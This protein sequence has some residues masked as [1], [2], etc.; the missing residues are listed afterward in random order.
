MA[1]QPMY[2]QIADVIRR[3]IESGELPRGGRLPTEIELC[4]RYNAS[5]N[6]IR[7]AIKRLISLRLVETRPGQGTFV[8]Q[9]TDPFVTTLSTDPA[10]GGGGGEGTSR[11]SALAS[12]DP[13]QH[14][15]KPWPSTPE[16]RVE[17]PQPW[18][19]RR[20]RLLSDS[21]QVIVREQR[22]HID[23]VPWSLQTTYYPM[24]FIT[25][26]AT[27]LLDNKDINGGTVAYLRSAINVRQTGYR[28][29]I[30]TRRPTAEEQGFFGVEPDSTVI[31]VTR[32]AFDQEKHPF[33]VTNT[34]FPAERNQF[35][36]DIGDGLPEPQY[37]DRPPPPDDD[38]PPHSGS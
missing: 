4:K 33:L 13:G 38:R 19:R 34:V 2:R 24:E 8:T 11:L 31:V 14:Q 29:W 17:I 36:Y 6:T 27:K 16:V 28:D 35:I 10:A 9:S 3:Q 18:M 12:V 23:D 15:P 21:D 30:L 22:R 20:L 5:R 1:Q 32:T 25:R 7:D 37:D 26:G